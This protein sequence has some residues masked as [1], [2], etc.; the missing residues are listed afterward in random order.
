MGYGCVIKLATEG[1]KMG[2]FGLVFTR[3]KTK[4]PWSPSGEFG[5]NL[6]MGRT[7]F[8]TSKKQLSFSFE[9]FRRIDVS[10]A[11]RSW[12]LVLMRRGEGTKTIYDL[13]GILLA[14][15]TLRAGTGRNA[16]DVP[17]SLISCLG[18]S[19]TAHFPGSSRNFCSQRSGPKQ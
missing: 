2:I 10:V 9:I 5:Q 3:Q 13:G 18:A 1:S 17:C 16:N 6:T 8:P 7:A 11:L 14:Q 15:R 4:P 12:G 19:P